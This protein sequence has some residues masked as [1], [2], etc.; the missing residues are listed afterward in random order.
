MVSPDGSIEAAAEP[1]RR[2][3]CSPSSNPAP[4]AKLKTAPVTSDPTFGPFPA[5]AVHVQNSKM[6][7]WAIVVTLLVAIIALDWWTWRRPRL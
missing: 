3:A 4:H 6:L 1:V 2:I 5:V 7:L